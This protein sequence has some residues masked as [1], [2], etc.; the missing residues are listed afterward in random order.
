LNN[1]D[2]NLSLTASENRINDLDSF[3]EENETNNNRDSFTI[4]TYDIRNDMNNQVDD[5]WNVNI[6]WIDSLK[7]QNSPQRKIQLYENLIQLLEQDTLNINELLVLRKVL[8][9]IW[10][11]D[12]NVKSK[13]D[14][15][16]LPNEFTSHRLCNQTQYCSELPTI[17]QH[18]AQRCTTI[19]ESLP[20]NYEFMR[21]Q[22][23]GQN[24][25]LTSQLIS[26]TAN[27]YVNDNHTD[28][29]STYDEHIASEQYYPSHLNPFQDETGTSEYV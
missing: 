17:R 15:I 26:T 2:E 13:N 14:N 19:D 20:S 11:T 24:T 6:T 16:A 1:N 10:P 4:N 28:A 7:E 18:K 3:H 25:N 22:T 12:D 23:N 8:A 5:T 21:D 27:S 9:K 29:M